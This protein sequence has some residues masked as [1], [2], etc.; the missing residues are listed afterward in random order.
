MTVVDNIVK[1]ILLK[2]TDASAIDLIFLFISI[3]EL[4]RFITMNLNN[5]I[6]INKKMNL[7][8][9]YVDIIFNII[10]I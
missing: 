4:Y 7:I 2:L 8:I 3:M 10:P 6:D 9:E 5:L 1:I